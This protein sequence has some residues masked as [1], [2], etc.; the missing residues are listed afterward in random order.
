MTPL[1]GLDAAQAAAHHLLV[2]PDGVTATDVEALVLSRFPEASVQGGDRLLV[3]VLPG[4]AVDGPWPPPPLPLPDW[5]AS[6]YRLVAPEQR[7]D[8]VP[9]ELRGRG[10]LLDAFADGEPVADERQL[11]ELALAV[12]RRTG[13]GLRVS[14]ADGML[15]VPTA[16]PD[17]LVYGEVWLEPDALLHVLEPHL[18]GVVVQGGTAAAVPP[19]AV[20]G[21]PLLQD[22]AER[23][24]WHAEAD[25]YD[26]AALEEPQVS[27]SYG[28]EAPAADGAVY[29]VAVEPAPTLPVVLGGREWTGPIVYEVR[30][31]AG[32]SG[33]LPADAVARVDAAARAVLAAVD[34]QAVD[35]DGFLVDLG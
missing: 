29:T 1:L 13:G 23:R 30:C 24:W 22:E 12:A 20:T 16:L 17:L 6:V 34:G 18:P 2:V 9:P 8:P 19:D 10:D 3:E 33:T 27:E 14:G 21:A 7:G 28:V 35:D 15:L 4:C 31:Y 25:A 32:P 26:A 5:V 11:V